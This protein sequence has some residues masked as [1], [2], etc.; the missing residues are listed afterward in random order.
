[1]TARRKRASGAARSGRRATGPARGSRGRRGSRPGPGIVLGALLLTLGLASLLFLPMAG[2][3][4]EEPPA[5]EAPSGLETPARAMERD[6]D[7]ELPALWDR[8]RVEVLNAGGVPG[9]AAQ[10][11]DHL[12]EA[13]FDVVYFG[14]ARAFG[15]EETTVLDR[16]G[17]PEAARAV[18][19]ALGVDGV[20]QS[21]DPDL[22]V[23]VTVLLGSGWSAPEPEAVRQGEEE[24]WSLRRLLERARSRD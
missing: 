23:D 13:G 14:N 18:A 22:L 15:R 7:A 19:R 9:M 20:Q 21:L 3:P 24:G 16:T 2:E 12:R 1:M 10:A 17:N 8:I 5:T 6:G 4:G 11:T